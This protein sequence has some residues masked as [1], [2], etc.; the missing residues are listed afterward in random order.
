MKIAKY[1]STKSSLQS[2]IEADVLNGVPSNISRRSVFIY[3]PANT[4][5]QSGV[6][7]SQFWKLD[8]DTKP[9]WENP[10]I[11]WTSR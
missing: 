2:V 3:K 10:L 1:L 7:A 8:F 5:M 6:H 11:G 4:T 9:S